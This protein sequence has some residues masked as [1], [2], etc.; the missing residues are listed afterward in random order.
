M[1][2]CL[3]SVVV[4]LFNPF[5]IHNMFVLICVAFTTAVIFSAWV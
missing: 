4:Y 3:V 5:T 1:V 2:M